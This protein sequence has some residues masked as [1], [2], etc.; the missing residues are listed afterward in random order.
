[1]NRSHRISCIYGIVA[2][3]ILA[4]LFP[5]SLVGC[6]QTQALAGQ[7]SSPEQTQ[8]EIEPAVKRAT[9]TQLRA[10][11][12]LE[13]EAGEDALEEEEEEQAEAPLVEPEEDDPEPVAASR[14]SSSAATTVVS[15]P[16]TDTATATVVTTEVTVETA[17]EE[18]DA[19]EDSAGE[20]AEDSNAGESAGE[21][22]DTASD[23]TSAD[24]TSTGST[25]DSAASDSSSDS[26]ASDGSSDTAS[27]SS[28][29]NV[30]DSAVSDGSSDS[31]G[32]DSTSSDSASSDSTSSD[33]SSSSSSS[34]TTV[35]QLVYRGNTLSI[36]PTV[37]VN[38]YDT[39]C[40][41]Y[42]G[43]S[44]CRYTGAG[45]T[46][47]V[48][49]D[50]SKYQG[51]IDWDKVAASG[52]EFAI[53][54]VGYRGYTAGSVNLDS[55]FYT[56]IE[57]ALAAGLKVGVYFF[58]QAIT[59]AEAKEEAQFVL[60]AIQGYNVTFPVAFDWEHIGTAS[61]RTD[62]VSRSTLTAMAN[63]FCSTV[64]AAGYQTS[65]YFYTDLGYMSYNLEDLPYSFWL[66]QY[67]T[68]PTFYYNFDMWQY[69][70]TGT[71]PGISGSVDM[72]LYFIPTT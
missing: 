18:T 24:S 40:F 41:T 27:D 26:V 15:S 19:G 17:G 2:S 35:T 21:A 53:I 4:C 54:R 1:M 62:N 39:S 60:S 23:S 3:M 67:S 36:L 32:S 61:A 56:N 9:L 16:K 55:Q 29:D 48:G 70:S 22:Q 14:Q 52:V 49:V 50:V 34:T 43:S 69:S 37:D 7:S 31:A 66:C 51:T 45:Y 65:V 10:A 58:S 64:Q 6:Q 59:T 72:D 46:S 13:G 5:L 47:M 38:T 11:A 44:L 57:G 20:T 68:V 42:Y 33:S 12:A 63:T 71:V 28:S 30:S 25:S 8:E